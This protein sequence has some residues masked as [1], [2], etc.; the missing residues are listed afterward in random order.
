M[1]AE[2][3]FNT[4]VNDYERRREELLW[5][6]ETYEE[7]ADLYRINADEQKLWFDRGI[8]R[9]SDY[10]DAQTNY[11]MAQNRV[12]SARI[13]RKLYNL[14]LAGLFRDMKNEEE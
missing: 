12:H 2:K 1:E 11:L 4:L 6:R 13:D 14:E 7:E 8:I 9:E 10:M 5:Q 3:K